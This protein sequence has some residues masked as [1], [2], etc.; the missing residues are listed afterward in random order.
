MAI[1]LLAVLSLGATPFELGLV[2]AASTIGF[3]L[4][5]LPAGAWVDRCTRRPLL[6]ASDLVRAAVLASIPVAAGL[7]VLTLTQLVVVALLTGFARVFVDVGYQSYLP[8]VVG[9]DGLLTGNAALETVRASGQ[10]AG[11][12]VG[13]WLVS[14][15]GA[16][17]VVLLQAVTFV[18]SAVSVL[19]IRAPEYVVRPEPR[20]VW[21][22]I[23]EGLVYVAQH[24]ALRRSRSRVR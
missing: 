21:S 14:A 15:I 7:G 24:R 16:A 13:G 9:K 23:R 12:G 22:E 19:A 18:V 11:P 4:V 17:N 3:A 6:V 2:S 5:G 1:P 10:V 8:T 20:G